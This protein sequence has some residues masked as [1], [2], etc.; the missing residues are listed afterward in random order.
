[1]FT[2]SDSDID[3]S[4]PETSGG[5]G[6]SSVFRATWAGVAALCESCWPDALS[7]IVRRHLPELGSTS[8]AELQQQYDYSLYDA[9][10]AGPDSPYWMNAA[11]L[12]KLGDGARACDVL[13]TMRD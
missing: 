1:M 11:K 2:S 3:A 4:N 9:M 6:S 12:I 5:A 13:I 7:D 10:Q 8:F